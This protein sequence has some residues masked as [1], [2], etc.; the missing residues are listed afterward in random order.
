MLQRD[1]IDLQSNLI[2]LCRI[3]HKMVDDQCET[4]APDVLRTIKAKHEEWVASTL[5]NTP[6]RTP[7]RIR[8]IKDNIP[9][10]LIRLTSGK[11]V[12]AVVNG[13]C[14]YQV[15]HDELTSYD[16]AQLVGAFLQQVQDYGDISNELE[17]GQLVRATFEISESLAELEQAGFWLFGAQELQRLEGGVGPSSTWPV[18]ILFVTRQ[19]NPDIATFEAG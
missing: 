8:K 2:L 19:N 3:H 16:E 17:A 11:E 18:A 7:L 13:A 1:Q 14:S 15:N 12:T 6:D 10:H 5:T 9:S 4:Y